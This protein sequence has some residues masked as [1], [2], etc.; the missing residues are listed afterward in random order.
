VFKKNLDRSA[1]RSRRRRDKRRGPGVLVSSICLDLQDWL[2]S[3]MKNAFSFQLF[4]FLFHFF[5]LFI[6][7]FRITTTRSVP[8][9]TIRTSRMAYLTLFTCCCRGVICQSTYV[10][11]VLCALRDSYVTYSISLLLLLHW[12]PNIYHV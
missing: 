2:A 3:I 11:V 12:S 1:P 10:D 9:V 7:F 6:G 5:H 8:F 4:T